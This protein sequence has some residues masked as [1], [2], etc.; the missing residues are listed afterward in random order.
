[1][2][3]LPPRL[4]AVSAVP[5]TR[6]AWALGERFASPDFIG[7]LVHVS[8]LNWATDVT[9][10]PDIH[11]EGVSA[12]SGSSTWVWGYEQPGSSW[13]SERPYLALVSGGVV[14]QE[15]PALLKDVYVGVMASDG[16]SDTFLVGGARDARG[17]SRGLV[18][19]RWDGTSWHRIPAPEAAGAITSLSI[20][21]SSDVWLPTALG[22]GKIGLLH[23]NGTSWSLSYTPPRA[24]YRANTQPAWVTVSSSGSQVQAAYNSV[25]DTDPESS[26]GPR[27]EP[28]TAYFDGSAWQTFR[29]PSG[30]SDLTDITVAGHSAWAIGC[31]PSPSV[32][33]AASPAYVVAVSSS[34]AVGC[35]RS[36]AYVFNGRDW[37][38]VNSRPAR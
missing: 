24:V 31:M 34:T 6:Q 14:R 32:I 27:S 10:R 23:W 1:V 12:V 21:G 11:L 38:S 15:Q 4:L 33:S 28:F 3:S 5:G 20:S 13:T 18:A 25:S 8:G 29:G 16:S 19:A 17:R 30:F 7:Y 22:G 2:A 26:P 36:F 9:F 35:G 37:R